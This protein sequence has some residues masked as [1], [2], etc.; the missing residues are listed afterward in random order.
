MSYMNLGSYNINSEFKTPE[1]KS[2][3]VIMKEY[4]NLNENKIKRFLNVKKTNGESAL[5]L[6]NDT[7]ED[8]GFIYETIGMINNFGEEEAVKFLESNKNDI[9]SK[10][11]LNSFIFEKQKKNY[12]AE[13][14]KMRTVIK[15]KSSGVYTCPRC[16]QKDTVYSEMQTRAGDEA[17]T[18]IVLCNE[19]GHTFRGQ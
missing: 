12:K 18:I 6:E 15:A 13:T 8:T 19:C 10:A 5:N 16:G 7:V 1:E 9:N 2:L 17:S 3:N 4:T 14:V 11:I